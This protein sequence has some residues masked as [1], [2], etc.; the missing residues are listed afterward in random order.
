MAKIETAPTK[1]ESGLSRVAPGMAVRR[2]NARM[3]MSGAYSATR[4]TRYRKV[5]AYGR[6]RSGSEEK[7]AGSYDR[8]RLILEGQDLY[9]NSVFVPAAC[10]RFASYAVFRGIKPVALSGDPEWN[11]KA[12]DFWNDVY[13][14]TVD[15]RGIAN[16]T[17]F[18]KLAITGRIWAGGV[19]FVMLKNGQLDPIEYERVQTPSE[20][21]S[22]K[23]VHNGVKTTARGKLLGFYVCDRKDGGSVDLTS[24]RYVP[25]ENCIHFWK[26]WRFDQML[27][28]P[29][30]A[31]LI[32][33]I[34]DFK[35]TDDHILLK[36]KSEAKRLAARTKGKGGKTMAGNAGFRG[37]SQT[38]DNGKVR[39]VVKHDWGE[40]Y[41]LEEGETMELMKGETPNANSI[42]YLKFTARLL[43][44]RFGVPYEFMLM[45]FESG[46][47]S[48]HRAVTLHSQHAFQE[49][50]GDLAAKMM[51]KLW[52]WRIAKAIK[53]GT[54]PAAPLKD[55]VS[56][57]WRVEWTTPYFEAN[58]TNKQAQGDKAY[59]ELGV[60]TV[61]NLIKKRNRKPEQVLRE[62]EQWLDQCA[63]KVEAHNAAH[64]SALVSIDHFSNAA[65]PGASSAEMA[66]DGSQT[67]EDG[68]NGVPSEGTSVDVKAAAD[69]YGV[70]VRAGALTPQ[71]SD[72][73]H[74]RKVLRL[75]EE[76]DVVKQ[77][78]KDAG[79]ARRPITLKAQDDFEAEGA[80][81]DPDGEEED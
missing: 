60:E 62:T 42:E 16:M 19:L 72:E 26:P 64:P 47:F 37:G 45:I 27:G 40:E 4:S 70:S 41:T 22:N 1:F 10:D 7:A 44:A 75:P 69:A 20:L 15:A 78:W 77:A 13:C 81:A 50:T 63:E 5:N 57:W 59:V 51:D 66:D 21:R 65:T 53:D 49:V 67:T 18:Q 33:K 74:F 11:R 38:D 61:P 39:E 2:Y 29:D 58:D 79:G 68:E 52:R 9:R 6:A 73:V 36:I 8:L 24:Y 48:S 55:G 35:E 28:I 23:N 3:A 54:L 25:E 46:S 80:G 76:E 43:S 14:Q 12:E 71:E 31:P 56:E 34:I 17:E 32:E 30:L